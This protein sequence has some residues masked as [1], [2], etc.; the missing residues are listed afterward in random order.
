MSQFID[1]LTKGHNE[2]LKNNKQNLYIFKSGQYPTYTILSCSDSRVSPINI[3]NQPLGKIFEIATP[4]NILTDKTL[5]Y[6]L[7]GVN[8][9]KTPVLIIMGHT[10]C[11]AIEALEN[12]E[13]TKHI[14]SDLSYIYPSFLKLSKSNVNNISNQMIYENIERTIHIL[15]SI[16]SIYSKLH[17]KIK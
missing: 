17:T 10:Q 12:Y 8:I 6:V 16:P 11:G 15:K 7:F 3:F 2:F 4:G 9:L 1:E 5:E 13:E 14:L